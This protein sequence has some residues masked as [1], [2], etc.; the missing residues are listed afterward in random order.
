MEKYQSVAIQE[1]DMHLTTFYT[2]WGLYWYRSAQQGY[3]AY[4]HRYDKIT[5]VV[6]DVKRVIDD[7]LLY[8]TDLE[9]AF[10]FRFGED[11]MD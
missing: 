8:A 10:K 1:E 3:Q 7:T 11:T 6:Q 5:L 2:K 9:G 4:T